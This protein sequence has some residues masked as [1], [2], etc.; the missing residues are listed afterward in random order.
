MTSE[1]TEILKFNEYQNLI[2]VKIIP[3]ILYNKS[4]QR[5]SIRFFKAYNII[6]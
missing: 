1:D 6:I 3:K 5:Y 4:R 2:D